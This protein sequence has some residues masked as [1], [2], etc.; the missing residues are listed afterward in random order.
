MRPRKHADRLFLWIVIGLVFI[1]TI[2][3]VSAWLGLLAR[4]EEGRYTSVLFK[5][6]VSVVLGLV[7]L[8]GAS[9][10]PYTFW[11]KYSFY[12]F[13]ASAILTALLFVPGIGQEVGGATRWMYLGPISLQPA[14]FLKIG[15]LVYFAALLSSLKKNINS[16]RDGI[17]PIGIIFAIVGFLLLKQPDTSTM[18]VICASGLA[19]F[20]VAGGWWRYIFGFVGMGF[21]G[22]AVL[23]FTRPYIM[24]RFLTFFDPARDA[25]DAGWQIKQSLIAIGSGGIAGRGFGQSIQKFNYLPEPIGDSIFAVA[26]EEF[27]F[28]GAL[29]IIALF[30]ALAYR[31]LKIAS[32]APNQ[33]GRLLIVGIVILVISQSFINIG[34]MLGVLPLTGMPLLFISHGGTA[35]IFVMATM[36]IILNISKFSKKL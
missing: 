27:G 33:F 10:I 11:K 9:H 12:I 7:A 24:D 31:G 13:I 32:A 23:A 6:A 36:G 15:F 3:F 35:L 16:F 26:A 25:L 21:A 8:V 2:I 1:G 20:I 19:M 14:E 18:V 22:L 4:G 29:V 30:L 28:L 17:L 5:H 34:A